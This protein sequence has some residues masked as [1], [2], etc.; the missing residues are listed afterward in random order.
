MLL[1]FTIS[2]QPLASPRTPFETSKEK[3]LDPDETFD[4]LWHRKVQVRLFNSDIHTYMQT[5]K[6]AVAAL[7]WL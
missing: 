6:G 4:V 2:V 3:L 1:E 7:R 5:Y